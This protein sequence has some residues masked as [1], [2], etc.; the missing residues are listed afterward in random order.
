MRKELCEA[1]KKSLNE[2]FEKVY[3]DKTSDYV[4]ILALKDDSNGIILCI[5]D[6]EH[7]ILAKLGSLSTTILLNCNDFVVQPYGLFLFARNI[8]E[9]IKKLRSKIKVILNEK[10]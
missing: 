10:V 2:L 4:S 7:Y 5:W 6:K 1:I 3:V 9:L 8:H